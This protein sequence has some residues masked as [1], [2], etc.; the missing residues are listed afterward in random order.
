MLKKIYLFTILGFYGCMF[1][2]TKPREKLAAYID[3]LY[4]HHKVMGSFAISD[5]NNS[6]FLKVVGMAD[7]PKQQK[8]NMNTEYR[9]G[10]V[11]KTFTAVLIMKAVETGKISTDTKLSQYY[12][13]IPNAE[14]ITVKNLLQH[15]SGIHNL[16][17]DSDFLNIY[18]KPQTGSALVS[19][20]K[21]FPSDFEPGKKYAYSNSNYILLGLILEKIYLKPYAELVEKMITKP[22]KLEKTKVGGKINTAENQAQSYQYLGM[23]V[24]VPESD[25]S[26]PIGAGNIVSTSTELITFIKA[27]ANGKLVSKKSLQLMTEFQDDYGFGLVK[28]QFEN[29]AGFGH[30]GVIDGFRSGVYYFPQADIALSYLTNQSS[31]DPQELLEKI[32]FAAF[33]KDFKIPEFKN[34]IVKAEILKKYEGLYKAAGFPLDIKIFTENGVL[35]AQATGQ[36]PFPLDAVS[37]TEFEF[38]QAGIKL[39]FD[40]PSGTMKFSQGTNNFTFKKQ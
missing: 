33:G 4:V 7:V 40:S 30:E 10:S 24:P 31:E 29:Q 39:I 38:T 15:R 2:Q 27:L 20:I 16:T 28:N 18:M 13:E 22:L 5:R 37:E 6:V 14:K 32:T 25:M 34:T 1:S 21:K 17:E 11:S 23:Y 9:V 3:S 8:A 12:P 36:G 35:N 26:V 19:F